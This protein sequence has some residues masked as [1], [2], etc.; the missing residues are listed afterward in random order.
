[1]KYFLTTSF[2][3]LIILSCN[4]QRNKTP[5]NPPENYPSHE[6]EW[7][8]YMLAPPDVDAVYML[9]IWGN[10]ENNVWCVGFSYRREYQIWHW[11]GKLWKNL[12]PYLLGPWKS[13]NGI[14]GFSKKDFWIIGYF[15]LDTGYILHY[16]GNWQ[17]VDS[18]Q[19]PECMSVWGSSSQNLFV[20]CNKGLIFRYNGFDFIR[21]DTGRN[22]QIISIWGLHTGQVFAIGVNNDLQPAQPPT[23][24]LFKFAGNHFSLID[25]SI[26]K[27]NKRETIGID[28]WG[29]DLN[30]LYSPTM[31]SLTKYKNGQWL[32]LFR[33][34][35]WRIFGSSKNN[36][37][38]GGFAGVLYHYNG[39]DW[40]R[41]NSYFSVDESIW[42]L[43]CNENYV[44]AIQ[45]AG[46]YTRILQGKQKI[47]EE[48][49]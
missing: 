39:I 49:R 48:R 2:L 22:L 37:F 29:T 26:S 38:T 45:H 44:F 16:D 18:D 19:I 42:G 4:C 43:W 30:N 27:P 10:D 11:D 5:L 13:Y 41:L 34:D 24:Y 20:G 25:S 9:D 17:V 36:I 14:F 7:T 6:F 1:M 15:N 23:R 32:T 31:S 47:I 46:N 3:G 8:S 35:L 40:Q 28:L 21:Y 33:A 12:E